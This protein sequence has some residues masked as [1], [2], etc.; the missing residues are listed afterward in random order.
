[1]NDQPLSHHQFNSSNINFVHPLPLEL[2]TPMTAAI[3]ADYRRLQQHPRNDNKTHSPGRH[4]TPSAI[5]HPIFRLGGFT[6][7]SSRW[8]PRHIDK[9][10]TLLGRLPIQTKFAEWHLQMA[11]PPALPLLGYIPFVPGRPAA[12]FAVSV[13]ACNGET[14][15]PRRRSRPLTQSRLRAK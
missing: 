11:A 6:L 10:S 8:R 3:V 4:E 2:E 14:P 1:M 9:E 7:L 12:Q 15:S 5:A 13:S